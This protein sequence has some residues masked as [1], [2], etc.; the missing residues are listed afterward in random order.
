MWSSN[1]KVIGSPP[2]GST[3]IFS[4]DF[5]VLQTEKHFSLNFLII[6]VKPRRWMFY[7]LKDLEE[8]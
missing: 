4:T 3:W 5:P 1:D 2:V 7:H 8:D 6:M